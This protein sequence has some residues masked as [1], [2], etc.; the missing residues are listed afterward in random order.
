M[1]KLKV[2][3]AMVASYFEGLIEGGFKTAA[4]GQPLFYPWRVLG[5]G[6]VLPDARTERRIRKL[7]KIYYVVSLPLMLTIVLTVQ[8]YGFYYALALIPVVLLVY[9]VG[10]LSLRRRLFA[11]SERLRLS[12]SLANSGRAHSRAILWF[13]FGVCILFVIGGIGM[14]LDRE[15]G[16]G[17]LST[18]FFGV[19]GTMIGYMLRTR[20]S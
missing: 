5:K 14:I 2:S 11:S 8:S 16:M 18:L 13:L 15:V 1:S 19:C 17:L 4:D 20:A 9:G 3:M 7:L 10:V 6:Y 12:E